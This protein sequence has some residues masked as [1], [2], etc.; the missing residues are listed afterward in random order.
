MAV[1]KK[2]DTVAKTAAPVAEKK[3]V[4]E[5]KETVKKAPAK[6]AAAKKAPAKKVVA[7]E[8]LHIQW[9][10][11]EYSQ[12]DLVKLA[13]A[14]YKAAGNKDAAEKID[15]YVKPEENAVYYVIN[16]NEG[17]IDV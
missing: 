8:S 7:K 9:A 1:A 6:K 3:A 4:E 15:L 17:R 2:A 16:G 12:E 11:K 5:K 14:A 13:K 10:G